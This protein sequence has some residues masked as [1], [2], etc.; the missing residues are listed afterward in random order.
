MFKLLLTPLCGLLVFLG[1]MLDGNATLTLAEVNAANQKLAGIV[2]SM[3]P[4]EWRQYGLAPADS[5]V[6]PKRRDLFKNGGTVGPAAIF[7]AWNGAAYTGDAMVFFGGGHADGSSNGLYGLNLTSGEWYEVAPEYPYDAMDGKCAYPSQAPTSYHTYDGI[8]YAEGSIYVWGTPG[9]ASTDYCWGNGTWKWDLAARKWTRMPFSGGYASA[10]DQRRNLIYYYNGKDRWTT[11]NPVDDSFQDRPKSG[12]LREH[13]NMVYDKTRDLMWLTDNGGT[14]YRVTVNGGMTKVKSPFKDKTLQMAGMDL[15]PDGK[16]YFWKGGARIITFDPETG[17]WSDQTGNRPEKGDRKIFS[18]WKFVDHLGVFVGI[19]T[20]DEAPWYWKPPTTLKQKTSFSGA[21]KSVVKDVVYLNGK[22]TGLPDYQ[23]LGTRPNYTHHIGNPMGNGG[24]RPDIGLLPDWT[25]GW[26]ATG[27]DHFYS[28]MM[29]V[30]NIDIPW[31]PGDPH[32]TVPWDSEQEWKLSGAH[33]PNMYWVPYLATGDE[34]Y[35]QQMKNSWSWYAVGYR[36]RTDT[37][38]AWHTNTRGIAWMFRTVAELASVDP[39]YQTA[40]DATLVRLQEL[41][42]QP[43]RAYWPIAG[44]MQDECGMCGDQKRVVLWEEAFLT[45]VLGHA[46]LLGH[47]NVRP[48][49]EK[50]ILAWKMLFDFNPNILDEY[51]GPQVKIDNVYL[52]TEEKF[53]AAIAERYKTRAW[54]G[55]RKDILYADGKNEADDLR[56]RYV[57]AGFGIAAIAG[58]PHA[59]GLYDQYSAMVEARQISRWKSYKNAV[60]VPRP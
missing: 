1:C 27:E 2:K 47:E 60:V 55:K 29:D 50:Q 20:F 45:Q 43:W 56:A 5:P 18:K 54:W 28:A 23:D 15:G 17:E 21:E 9:Y 51:L 58:V 12:W 53:L 48:F 57:L 31:L 7:N 30:A 3:K 4:G 6:F 34:K 42:S 52:D 40:L 25:A 33:M 59:Q 22:N 39:Y 14:L 49:L 36:G 11:V 44:R 46:V 37:D 41:Q 24:D 26:L 10:Y 8:L 35:L 38:A 32:K 13:M 16:L 19:S